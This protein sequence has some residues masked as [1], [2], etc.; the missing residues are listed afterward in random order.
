MEKEKKSRKLEIPDITMDD[1]HQR[2][3]NDEPSSSLDCLLTVVRVATE[4]YEEAKN[5]F[6]GADDDDDDDGKKEESFFTKKKLVFKKLVKKPPLTT[7][8]KRGGCLDDDHEEKR[9]SAKEKLKKAVLKQESV[10]V[11]DLPQEFRDK[12]KEL[13]CTEPVLLIQKSLTK[14][15][16]ENGESR[17]SIP[18]GQVKTKNPSNFLNLDEMMIVSSK[19]NG[20]VVVKTFIEPS[21][22]VSEMVFKKW[23][24]RKST[25]NASPMFVLINKWNDVR[26]RN[27]LKKG[28]VVQVWAFKDVEKKL[29]LALVKV[30]SGGGVGGDGRTIE[31]HDDEGRMLQ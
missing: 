9:F 27:Q 3:I 7:K 31:V 23:D 24:M 28:D 25:G 2:N 29:G 15:D 13:K 19:S 10:P 8:L 17:L 21:V 18:F 14:T 6:N 26:E 22:E 5:K 20:G 11:P 4:K 1:F 30:A 16:V 12:M